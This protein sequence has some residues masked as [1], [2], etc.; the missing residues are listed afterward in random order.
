MIIINTSYGKLITSFVFNFPNRMFPRITINTH[1]TT[2]IVFNVEF[3]FF[4]FVASCFTCFSCALRALTLAS[5][6]LPSSI[7]IICLANDVEESTSDVE[8]KMYD[9]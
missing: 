4:N 8:A 1:D 9:Y 3:C 2:N 6:E 5:I 7:E